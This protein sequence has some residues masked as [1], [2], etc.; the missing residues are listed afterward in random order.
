MFWHNAA[1]R[2]QK[3]PT[4]PDP[5]RSGLPKPNKKPSRTS[6]AYNMIRWNEDNYALLTNPLPIASEYKY[7]KLKPELIAAAKKRIGEWFHRIYPGLKAT[8]QIRVLVHLVQMGYTVQR[9]K[10]SDRKISDRR[11]G[12]HEYKITQG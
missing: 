11:R 5:G 1:Q 8:D 2:M 6:C 7:A 10:I 9:R 12:V 3:K 4:E